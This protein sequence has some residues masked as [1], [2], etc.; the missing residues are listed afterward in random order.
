MLR[1][2]KAKCVFIATTRQQAEEL[3]WG[4]LKDVL[5]KLQIG[6]VFNETKLKCVLSKNGATLRLCGADDKREIDKLRGQPFHEVIVDESASYDSQLLEH[7]IYR[8]VG[9]RLGDY[10]G[11]LSLV[12]T[13]GHLLRG[14]FFDVSKTGSDIS[15]PYEKRN[16]PEF[17]GWQRWSMHSWNLSDGAPFVPAMQ[18]LWTEALIEKEANGWTDENPVWRREYLAQ[19]S[20]DDTEN[21]FRYAVERNSWAPSL[22]PLTRMA[23]LQPDWEY[24]YGLDMGHSD[25]FAVVVFGYSPKER[26]LWHVYS[27]ERRNMYARTIAELLIGEELNADKPGGLIGATGWPEAIVSDNAGLGDAMLDELGNVYGIRITAAIKRDKFDAIANF[28]GD[29]IDG[30]VKILKGSTLEDQLMTLQWA[31]DQFGKIKENRS[32]ANH[33]TDAAIYARNAAYHKFKEEPLPEPTKPAF[34]SYANPDEDIQ[35]RGEFDSMLSD[36]V[37][38]DNWG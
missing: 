38:N 30:R 29:L 27:F 17:S 18:R 19:W 13:P 35:P 6:A 11:C 36:S 16:D 23:P 32:Q 9:P 3:M 25:P 5:E 22:D 37:F 28:N 33:S 31:E 14:P 2:P 8:I 34:A 26:I 24:V 7:L 10:G 1:T 21:V 4:P 15:R 20:A 12:G